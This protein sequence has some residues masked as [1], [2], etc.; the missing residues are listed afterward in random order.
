MPSQFIA[1][2]R[3][4]VTVVRNHGELVGKVLGSEGVPDIAVGKPGV[5]AVRLVNRFEQ[6]PTLEEAVSVRRLGGRCGRGEI[7]RDAARSIATR[8]GRKLRRQ[9]CQDAEY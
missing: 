4:L 3:H 6:Q 9:Y 2:N 5:A 1:G 7:R 8:G